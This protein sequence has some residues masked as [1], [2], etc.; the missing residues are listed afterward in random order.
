Q[1]LLR[2]RQGEPTLARHP[3]YRLQ[4]PVRRLLFSRRSDPSSLRPAVA[5]RLGPLP[6]HLPQLLTLTNP[7][8]PPLGHTL[9]Y[10]SVLVELHIPQHLR[11]RVDAARHPPLLLLVG[12]KHPLVE[13]HA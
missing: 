10:P 11:H 5:Q 6:R 9:L 4:S 12:L 2:E 8:P 3:R 13:L 7:L 1:T